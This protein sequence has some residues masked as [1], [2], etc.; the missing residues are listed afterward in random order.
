[1]KKTQVL[2]ST[3]LWCI[4]LLITIALIWCGIKLLRVDNGYDLNPTYHLLRDRVIT[5]KVTTYEWNGVE[6]LNYQGQDY[7]IPDTKVILLSETISDNKNSTNQKITKI[8][9]FDEDEHEF[10][11]REEI[12]GKSQEI[13]NARKKALRNACWA[14]IGAIFALS[15][16]FMCIVIFV[17]M[18]FLWLED[19]IDAFKK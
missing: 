8:I 9:F 4:P 19:L 16:S 7:L 12:I 10:I 5:N 6:Y 3:W 17:F 14:Y 1:M 11:Y 13:E 2:G 18:F 15:I